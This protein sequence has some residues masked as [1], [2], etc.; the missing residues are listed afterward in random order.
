ME[1]TNQLPWGRVDE[2]G[3]VFVRDT[4]GERA[5][6]QFPDGSPEE[7]LAYF[8]RKFVELAG[9]VTLLEQRAKGGA[10]ATDIARAVKTLTGQLAEA[11]A[12]GDLENLRKRLAALDT[13]VEELTAQQSAE[14]KAATERAV[15]ERAEIVAEIEALAAVDPTK[16]QWKQAT[17][18]LDDLFT[19]WQAHQQ[20]NPRLPKSE[21]NDL[22]KRFRAAR[23][24][25]ET[26]RK[27]F[28]AQLD[29]THKD[30]RGQK[31]KLIERAEALAPQGA[32]GIP[33]YRNLLDEWKAAPRAGKRHDDALWAK[34]KVAGDVLFE[35]KSAT[36]AIENEEFTANLELKRALLDEAEPLLKETNREKAKKRLLEVQRRWDEIGK[37]PR[38]QVKPIEERLRTIEAAV[39]KLD[40][41][42]WKKNNPETKARSEGLAGQLHDA[43]AKLEAE[44]AEAEKS[45]DS[46]KITEAKEALTA[47]KAWLAAIG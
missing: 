12:V 43:I 21:S 45:G 15:A 47:R 29:A 19:R 27:A 4:D 11:N 24:T 46:K 39:R 18:A 17:V 22:W 44:L 5:V 23:T 38:D 16:V 41:D 40:E 31:Q 35:A 32:Q 30:A 34:F 14:Q 1:S 20:G 13:T 2:T 8:E 36:D 3:T 6:G 33:A 26:N 42:F 7:A 9:Q 37:V 10:P 25:I 28:F